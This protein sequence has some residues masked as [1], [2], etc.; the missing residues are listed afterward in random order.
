MLKV[1]RWIGAVFGGIMLLFWIV[2]IASLFIK[3]SVEDNSIVTI[4]LD[5]D[6][7]EQPV[8]DLANFFEGRSPQSFVDITEGI[9][10]AATDPKING[11]VLNVRSPHLGVAQIQEFEEAL[12][13]FRSSGKWNAAFL[14]TAGEFSAGDGALALAVC[15]DEVILAPSGDVTLAGFRSE[16]PFVKGTLEMLDIEAHVEKRQDYK[17]AANMFTEDR[18]TPEH[19]LAL[20]G[21]VD[22]LQATLSAHIAKRRNVDITQVRQWIRLSPLSAE[23]ALDA[24]IVDK[25]AYWDA[26]LTKAEQLN[27]RDDSL[28]DIGV[29]NDRRKH[30]TAKTKIALITGA[31][32]IV[33]GS[34][35]ASF[36][37][38]TMGSN[39]ITEA[40]RNA[41]QAKV[42][43]VLFRIDSPGGSYIASD[44][45]RREVQL[46][47]EAGIPVVASMGN[48]AASGGYYVAM[49]A[50]RIIAQPGSI[51]GSIGILA[52][53]FS[54][55]KALKRW[56][57]VTFDVY[58]THPNAFV[59]SALDPMDET[60]KERFAKMVDR[61]YLDFTSKAAKDR[62]MPLEELDAAAQGRV[63]SGTAAHDNKLIDELGGFQLAL[64][65]L[66][67]IA[68]L[69]PQEQI[70][71]VPFPEEKQGLDMLLD[72]LTV[73]AKQ[74]SIP[75]GQVLRSLGLTTN[76]GLLSL[77]YTPAL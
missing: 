20:K 35:E 25:T 69:A 33:R 46:T 30:P 42:A 49:N 64:K 54:L 13:V 24:K 21:V 52:I 75:W 71:L 37:A 70:E 26:V 4:T 66:R 36:N 67:E 29:Y 45:I 59:L 61:I 40:F 48:V 58:A 3:P 16:V 2:A 53:H 47:R 10:A 56:L 19:L 9:R 14:E 77:P 68:K 57:G 8:A 76:H 50:D 41:R 38:T 22:D 55:R 28:L 62:D 7:P 60:Q 39:T 63:W 1:F 11:L 17:S 31:G 6:I 34:S 44:L 18:F 15:A 32:E 5:G 23:Q 12:A 74:S 51:T 73:S 65:H 27:H 72:L 43:G